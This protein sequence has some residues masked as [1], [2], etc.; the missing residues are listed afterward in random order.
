MV[1]EGKRTEY[2]GRV[3]CGKKQEGGQERQ[4]NELKS[5]ASR[6]CRVRG[7]GFSRK[8]QKPEIGLAPRNQG[9]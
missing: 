2:K 7:G 5:A 4:E 6:A 3:I 8:S 9:R 1:G